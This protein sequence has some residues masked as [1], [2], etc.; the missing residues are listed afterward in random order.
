M[1]AKLEKC[2]FSVPSIDFL[3]YIISD[4]GIGVDSNKINSITSWPAPTTVK[5]LQSF[6][7]FANFYRMFIA[8][9]SDIIAPM[10][11]LLKKDTKFNWNP[12]C[13]EAFENL[14]SQFSS[15]P[16]LRHPDTSKPFIVEAD[17]SDFAIG[18]ILSQDIDG[19]IHPIAY[20]SRKLSVPEINYKVHDKELLAIVA[21]FQQW[22][23]FLLS[24]I[25][26]VKVLTDH[27]NLLYFSDSKRLNRRQ[28]R[29]SLF[30]CD[31]DF[32]IIFR[33]GR[34]GGKP[35]ALSRRQ[36]Y[37]LH[38]SDE[39]VTNQ[40]QV[41]LNKNRFLI[42]VT[43]ERSL[44]ECIKEAQLN[45]KEIQDLKDS[46][47]ISCK[48]DC[49]LHYGCLVIPNALRHK[50]LQLCHDSPLA[51]HA[52]I[53]KTFKLISKEFWW[54]GMRKDCTAYVESCHV[55]GRAKATHMKPAGLL[56]PLPVPPRP[57]HSVAMDFIVDLP[58]VQGKDSILVIVDRFSKMGHFVA[59]RK[60]ITSLELADLFFYHIIRLH[61]IPNNLVTDRG[62]VFISQFFSALLR[63]YGIA[64]NLSSAY[65]PQSDGQTK[66]LN[67]VLEQYLCVYSNFD[68]TNWLENLPLAEFCYNSQFHTAI[69]MSPFKATYG[70]DP[71]VHW[72]TE[73]LSDSP[74]T[75]QKYMSV[76]NDT[77]QTL[78]KTLKKTQLSTKKF[79][80]IKRC[81]VE[82]EEGE[83]VFLDR[84]HIKTLRPSI[85]LDWKKLGPFQI[86]QKINPVAYR[87]QLPHSMKR[88]HNVFH[89][90]LLHPVK[91]TYSRP[92][93][94]KPPPVILDRNNDYY[95]VDDILDGK[96]TR[97]HWQ[98]LVLWKGY[99]AKE[100][101]WEPEE[102]I[103]NCD[104][105]IQEFKQRF[106]ST[107]K[108]AARGA[109]VRN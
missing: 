86:I 35:D 56:Q 73:L 2:S 94:A 100:N 48:D 40:H 76:L 13:Q 64:Q 12:D 54:P 60:N 43:R 93:E 88:L 21:C 74:Q 7:G 29:W 6:L 92:T 11:S 106:G 27:R 39:R 38:N 61:G 44:L 50:L 82:Y 81:H 4:S 79:A 3:G 102:N 37:H 107:S 26:P 59:C 31:F 10:L 22:Q 18:G 19:K 104:H 72:S 71:P 20:Y 68:Q 33:P 9:Y 91:N 8:N 32:Q 47:G 108:S 52:G 46:K 99:S 17:A 77:T 1:Y 98:F 51:G 95:E 67:Q 90:L 65:H 75:L 42:A 53:R 62:S 69:N 14:Q 89:I 41:L 78:C 45:D 66:R 36:D 109:T 5:S 25:E 34:E 49:L 16:I 55:C 63:N 84:R 87:L 28:V 83:M 30:L 105:L 103:V 80:D 57:W 23:S 70:F 101:S 24:S 15:A 58:P 85:K 96:R 97:G